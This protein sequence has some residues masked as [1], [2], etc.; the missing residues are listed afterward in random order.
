MDGL[1]RWRMQIEH[2]GLGGSKLTPYDQLDR[3]WRY[4]FPLPG[5]WLHVAVGLHEFSAVLRRRSSVRS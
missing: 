5:P 2:R 4:E 1:A 3:L